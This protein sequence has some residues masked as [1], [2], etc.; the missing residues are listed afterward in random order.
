MSK[1]VSI[2][3]DVRSAAAVRQILFEAQRGY[4]YDVLSVPPRITDIRVVIKDLDDKIESAIDNGIK[5]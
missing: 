4:T 3:M 5:S 1:S 2:K